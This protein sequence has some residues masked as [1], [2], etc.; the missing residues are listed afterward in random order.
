MFREL[1]LW[2]NVGIFSAT[3][4]VVWI[5]GTR[6]ADYAD[7]IARRTGIGH[8]MAGLILLAG[9]TSLPEVAVTVTASATGN[10]S[11]AVNNLLGSVAMQVAILAVADA[12]I[13]RDS[14]TSVIPDPTVLLQIALNVLVLSLVG[15][16][17]VAG[18]WGVF[19]VGAWSCVLLLVYVGA[20]W[21]LAKSG[22]RKPWVAEG[23]AAL[24]RRRVRKEEEEK[25][26]RGPLR[27]LFAKTA[28]GAVAIL[29]AGFL[30]SKTGEAIADQTGLGQSLGG[31]LL[32]AVSTSLPEVSTVVA[33]VRLGRYVMAVS[34]IFGTNLFNGGLVFVVDAVYRGGPVLNE[35]GGFTAFAAALGVIVSALF[36]IGLIER[37]D[38]TVL[39]MGY[40]SFAVLGA[41]LAGVAV[42]F[43]LR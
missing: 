12:I 11:L 9:I 39:R 34:D 28:A 20:I 21:L 43:T 23:G 19:G 14:L 17:V 8:A 7:A 4:V 27:R 26:E 32:V 5:A 18:D 24:R 15:G 41:Y 6:V 25:E 30:L 31:Y 42:L 37:R 1:S 29:V 40:D 33:A 10:A 36:L 22:E 16:A 35:V 3:A 13:G 38:R 2:A